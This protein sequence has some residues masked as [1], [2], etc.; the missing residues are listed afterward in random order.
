MKYYSK[1]AATIEPYVPG[2]QPQE[3]G[4][5]KLNTNE[6]P[7]P[8]SPKAVAAIREAADDDLRL[9][10]DPDCKRLRRAFSQV[11]K[12]DEEQVFVGNGSDEV[13]AVAFQA[14]FDSDAPPILFPDISYSFYPVYANLYSIPYTH[15]P[16]Q[17]DFTVGVE[18]YLV[19]NGG[20]ILSNPN[21]PTAI[22]MLPS[23]IIRLLEHNAKLGRV[24]V[25]DEAYSAFGGQSM[26]PYIKDFDNLV[27]TTSLSKSYSLAGL[28][29]GF[30]L[31]QANLVDALDRIKNSFNSY[32]LDRLAIAGA[33]E[34]V[35][36]E[37]YL[38]Q[39]T[40]AV[41][42][43]RGRT[44]T[45]LEAM[46]F[47]VLPSS[48]NF[49]FAKHAARAGGELFAALRAR[50]V[51]VRHFAKPRIGEYL[52]ITI[53]TDVQMDRFLHTLEQILQEG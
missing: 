45:A 17:A 8:P 12:V 36:D 25:V 33:A 39:T 23:E 3:Q 40:A 51:Y 42:A 48:A 31:C 28:R 30:A 52:R 13:L 35:L 47:D 7:Y 5:L 46:G 4:I 14:F 44:V 6:N 2:E 10:P 26:V 29:G 34:A 50:G 18:D 1:I 32:T 19:D 24:V 22:A 15:V 27:V 43:T 20:I 9:Y 16:L 41:V 53:G 38:A 21:A 11:M 37:E 49:V